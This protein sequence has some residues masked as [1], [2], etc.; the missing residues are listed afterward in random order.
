MNILESH[1][2]IKEL[3]LLIR[4]KRPIIYLVSQEENR[5][6]KAIDEICSQAEPS[7]DLLQW[8]IVSGLESSYPEFLPVKA[9][10]R[11]LDQDE[12]LNWFKDLVVPKNKYAILV[13]KDFNKF[14]GSNSYKNQ[15]EL[16]VIRQIKNLSQQLI[17][18][19]KTLIILSNSMDI[20]TELEKFL[21]VLDYPL[22]NKSEIKNKISDLLSRASQRKNLVDKFKTKYTD[23][24]LDSIVNSFRGL[25]LSECEQVCAYCIIKHSELSPDAISQQKKDIIRKSGLLD[26]IDSETD[27][28]K[29]GGLNGLKT[30]LFKRQHAFSQDAVD[31]GLPS[32][33]KGILLVGIQGAGKSLFAKAVSSY[34]NF[35]LLR[36]DMGKIFSGLVGSSE[37]NMRQVFRVAESVAPC[38][39]WCD[40]ID[41][42]MSGSRS[43]SSTD[44]GTTSRVL[45]SWLT[46]MQE[47]TA[48][49]FVIATANDVSN[50][51]PELLRKGRFDEIFF[52]DLPNVEERKKIFQIHI[53]KRGRKVDN[54]N[55]S[56]LAN[57]SQN[58][59]GAEIESSIESAMYEAFSDNKREITTDDILLSLENTVPISKLMREDIDAL[60]KWAKERARNASDN[61]VKY[62]MPNKEEEL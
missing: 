24:E 22:P 11:L 51:P 35:P 13:V 10:E 42:G 17:T 9:N 44:G 45:G 58:Y 19:N 12:I 43:S 55:I 60:R 62:S 32:S 4:S 3:D 41:K 56:T 28:D 50:L 34:W 33:P 2:I 57:E 61:D 36:L 14:F 37:N 31:Y 23:E 27:L 38:I 1:E 7:W 59:T 39:L 26:W 47:R 54:F 16:R 29:I 5:V 25:T 40:E 48:P 15:I 18:E 6:V 8:D 53:E 49:V 20:P 46:W 21:P 30:W 52:V